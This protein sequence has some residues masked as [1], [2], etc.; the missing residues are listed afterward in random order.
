MDEWKR[1]MDAILSFGK[2]NT[3]VYLHYSLSSGPFKVF[4]QS[5]M[6]HHGQ[7][8]QMRLSVPGV[9]NEKSILYQ[10][11]SVE[12]KFNLQNNINSHIYFDLDY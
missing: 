10:S 11:C 9:S 6:A 3:N 2:I 1:A 8:V 7:K 5:T 4:L 12:Q